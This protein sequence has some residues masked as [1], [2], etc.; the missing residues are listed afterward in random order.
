MG[1]TD[2]ATGTEINPVRREPCGVS[3]DIQL[4]REFPSHLIG[5][6]ADGP[7]WELTLAAMLYDEVS[8]AES[9]QQRVSNGPVASDQLTGQKR[10]HSD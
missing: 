4:E 1:I 7:T 2:H 8:I 6:F 5:S 9:A 10:A 3:V